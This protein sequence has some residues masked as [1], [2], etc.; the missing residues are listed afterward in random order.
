MGVVI[1][2][3]VQD[4]RH[5]RVTRRRNGVSHRVHQRSRERVMEE[6][7]GVARGR[8]RGLQRVGIATNDNGAAAVLKTISHRGLNG[9]VIDRKRRDAEFPYLDNFPQRD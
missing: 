9:I 6:E 3:I 5:T 1:E 8:R 4:P 7:I 2:N